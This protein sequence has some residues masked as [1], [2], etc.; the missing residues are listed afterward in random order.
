MMLFI[1]LKKQFFKNWK[2]LRQVTLNGKLMFIY[3]AL[4]ALIFGMELNPI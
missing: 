1:I 3:Q 2:K 4:S